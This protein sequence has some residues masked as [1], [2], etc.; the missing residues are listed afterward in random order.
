MSNAVLLCDEA[1]KQLEKV[2]SGTS[3]KVRDLFLGYVWNA[4][5]RST[6][7]RIGILFFEEV[8]KI[9]DKIETSAKNSANQQVYKKK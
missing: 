6:R 1:I 8:K 7:L 3:F 5:D 9:K 4:F 2:P